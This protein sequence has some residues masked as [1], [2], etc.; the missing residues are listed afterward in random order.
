MFFG[1]T[2]EPFVKLLVVI[3]VVV[4]GDGVLDQTSRIGIQKLV[5]STFGSFRPNTE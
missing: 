5:S 1:N 3:L 2:E 4:K